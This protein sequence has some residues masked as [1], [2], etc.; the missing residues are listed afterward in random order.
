[1]KSK[2][3]TFFALV[4]SSVAFNAQGKLVDSAPIELKGGEIKPHEKLIIPLN[5]L[6]D[7]VYYHVQ[8]RIMNPNY[9]KLYPVVLKLTA[10]SAETIWVNHDEVSQSHGQAKLKYAENS[11]EAVNVVSIITRDDNLTFVSLDDSDTVT[12]TG[13]YARLAV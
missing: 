11:Y 7:G 13:C 3:I 4:I 5:P 9:N 10:T 1:M 6:M 12:V 2:L 8:C